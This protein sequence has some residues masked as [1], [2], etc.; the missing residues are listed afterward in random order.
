VVV[1]WELVETPVGPVF[2]AASGQGV[3]MLKLDVCAESAMPALMALL[4]ER[5]PLG[6]S[7]HLEEGNGLA[8]E[9]SHQVTEYFDGSRPDIDLPVDHAS[10]SLFQVRIRETVKAVP[11]G[12][13]RTY[14]EIADAA[15]YPGAARAVGTVMRDNPVQLA[16]PC[17]RVV[18]SDGLG[19][20]G[21]R[22][23]LKVWL[24]DHE[25]AEH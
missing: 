11:A 25:G 12:E 19:G 6:D 22:E 10:A 9:A 2:V 17:H 7:V 13:T 8:K 16:V 20:F 24:L 3:V 23:D 5:V 1:N 14:G 18:A 15:G 21:G 4:A